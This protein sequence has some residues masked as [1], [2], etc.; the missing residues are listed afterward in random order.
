M[1]ISS[2]NIY[3]VKSMAPIEPTEAFVMPQGLQHDRRFA[4]I[5][6]HGRVV[7]RREMPQ[8]LH[9]SVQISEHGDLLLTHGDIEF[10]V[11]TPNMQGERSVDLFSSRIDGVIDLGDDAASFVS[12]ALGADYRMVYFG[13]RDARAVEPEIIGHGHFT[14]FADVYPI[15]IT[16]TPSLKALQDEGSYAFEMARFRPN[17][18]IEGDFPAWSE[19]KWQDITIGD[20]HL[21]ICKPCERCVM[22]LQ[23]PLSGYKNESNE[24]LRTLG[25]IHRSKRGRIMFGQNAV[26]IKSGQIKQGDVVTILSQ[27]QSNLLTN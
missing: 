9:F 10:R 11:N 2:L 23:D 14:G 17:I 8:L 7:T 12:N 3:P 1:K 25:R 13:D 16:T 24:P 19:D 20:V 6:R 15:L 21:R 27:G 18:V 4:L 5:D 26:V 22:T